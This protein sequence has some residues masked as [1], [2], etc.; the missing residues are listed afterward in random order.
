MSQSIK[1]PFQHYDLVEV[2]WSD[3]SEME[4][5]WAADIKPPP[6]ALALSVGF[7]IHKDKDHTVLALDTDAEGHHNGRSQIPTPMVKKTKILR[8]ADK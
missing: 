7:L 5:G 2:I 6:M 8:K 1:R 3:A 4:G